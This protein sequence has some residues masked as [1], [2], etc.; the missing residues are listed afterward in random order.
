MFNLKNLSGP[1]CAVISHCKMFERD[2]IIFNYDKLRDKTERP[3]YGGVRVE[4]H[5]NS[6]SKKKI[7]V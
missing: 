7:C 2:E 1:G 3:I 5:N 4:N 6:T